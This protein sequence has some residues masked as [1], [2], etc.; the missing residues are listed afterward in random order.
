MHYT[1]VKEVMTP[2]PILIDPEAT[3]Q[4]AAIKMQ[5]ANCGVLPV[6][7]GNNLQGVITDRD[8]VIR[9]IAE[10]ENPRQNKVGDHMTARVFFCKDTDSLAEAAKQMCEHRVSRLVVKDGSGRVCGIL[11]FG[12]ILR[13]D[14]NIEEI[15]EVVEC[16]FGKKKTA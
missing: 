8:I 2:H 9:A 5:R 3:L 16:A 15:G 11:S 13:K 12:C 10:G 14:K 6:G 4:E 1:R 7:E